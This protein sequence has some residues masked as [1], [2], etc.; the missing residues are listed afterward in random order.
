MWII[1]QS[2]E[3][4]QA[5]P[6]A[7]KML[8]RIAKVCYGLENR[9]LCD[10]ADGQ[11][12]DCVTRRTNFLTVLRDKHHD[13][14]FE[15]AVATFKITTDRGITHEL[16][17]HRIASFTQSSTRYIKYN[18]G[19]QV[20]KPFNLTK[21]E[22]GEWR[23]A[24]VATEAAYQRLLNSGTPPE[25]ARDV[26]PTCTAATIIITANF[27]EWR[28]ILTLR[29]AADAHPKIRALA[30]L[31]WQ[32]LHPLCPVYFEDLAKLYQCKEK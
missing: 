18:N 23:N 6:D 22:E 10:C 8:E 17:R 28:H 13:S 24:I 3:L 29:L 30:Y 31:I 9:I 26:L 16:V 19:I 25:K 12:A 7:A 2:A 27:R 1:E 21:A 14:V 5:T 4:I 32:Q 11:C 15:H 20:V